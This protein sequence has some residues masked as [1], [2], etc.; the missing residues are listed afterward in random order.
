MHKHVPKVTPNAVPARS[1]AT[2]GIRHMGKRS[3]PLVTAQPRAPL[4]I[5][6]AIAAPTHDCA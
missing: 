5:A 3:R 6:L 4:M 1:P 2:P